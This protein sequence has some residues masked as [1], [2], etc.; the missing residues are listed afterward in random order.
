MCLANAHPFPSP[1]PP[2]VLRPLL[3]PHNAW[4]GLMLEAGSPLGSDGLTYLLDECGLPGLIDTLPCFIDTDRAQLDAELLARWPAGSLRFLSGNPA[5][6]LPAGW[7]TQAA[8]SAAIQ[9][10]PTLRSLLLNLLSLVASDVDADRIESLIKRDASLAYK[11]LKMVNSVAFSPEKKIESFSRAIMVLGRRQLQRWI[12]LLLFV[13]SAGGESSNPLLTRAAIR[14]SLMESLARRAG[15]DR[16]QQDQAFMIGMFSLL[17][18]LF[19]TPLA[20][21]IAPLNL[22]AEVASVLLERQGTLGTLL[23]LAEASEVAPGP[24]LAAALA[25]AGIVPADWAADLTAALAWAVQ[26]SR[27]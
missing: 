14:A 2:L 27:N 1:V 4:V 23:T 3:D 19:G 9:G 24:D 26:V 17:G 25:A 13:Q 6:T 7:T 22:P 15:M 21:I 11:L 5:D 10:D 8:P 12:T 18:A 20:Q 16:E